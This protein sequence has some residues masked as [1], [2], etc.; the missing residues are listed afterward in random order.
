MIVNLE[1]VMMDD[2]PTADDP[3]LICMETEDAIPLLQDL[4]VAAVGVANNHAM[5]FGAQAYEAMVGAL[6]KSGIRVLERG[7]FLDFDA[8]R[9]YGFTD[10]DNSP[11][12]AGKLLY[13]RDI[14]T[15]VRRAG[16]TALPSFALVHWGDEYRDGMDDRQR[17]L[18]G[19]LR[20]DGISLFI[21]AHSHRASAMLCS[22]SGCAVPSLGNFL[23]DQAGDAVSGQ[24]LKVTFFKQGTYFP[25]TVPL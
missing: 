11:T 9:L 5:D 13:E 3:W 6:R 4:R 15:A 14:G 8:F 17:A 16:A 19:L 23:F 20:R 22:G 21:G 25:Q 1:G 24:I 2:C 7:S 10:L 18:A 12:P